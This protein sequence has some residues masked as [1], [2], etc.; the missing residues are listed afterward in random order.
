MYIY[1]YICIYICIYINKA[2]TGLLQ[3]I[4]E[5]KICK[6]YTMEYTIITIFQVYIYI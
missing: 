2:T 4:D 3:S 1:I 5:H 6:F